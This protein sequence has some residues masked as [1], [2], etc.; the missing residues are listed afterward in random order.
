MVPTPIRQRSPIRAWTF[1]NNPSS[2]PTESVVISTACGSNKVECKHTNPGRFQH[3]I[4]VGGGA[5]RD[6]ART[7]THRV[8]HVGEFHNPFKSLVQV[9]QPQDCNDFRLLDLLHVGLNLGQGRILHRVL[10]FVEAALHEPRDDGERHHTRH[11]FERIVSE[12]FE[13]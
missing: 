5:D 8:S 3:A 10:V 4:I 7:L 1:F 6:R 9:L 13:V 11:H 2:K 12:L